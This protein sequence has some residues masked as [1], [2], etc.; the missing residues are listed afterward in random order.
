MTGDSA[1]FDDSL[2]DE[3][4]GMDAERALDLLALG[5]VLLGAFGLLALLL[6]ALHGG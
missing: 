4:T 6:A 5:L 3:A 2:P 1:L